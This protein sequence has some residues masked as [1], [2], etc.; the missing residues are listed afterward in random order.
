MFLLYL[1][2]KQETYM[3]Y[4]ISYFLFEDVFCHENRVHNPVLS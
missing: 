4:V 3:T 2:Q 1:L